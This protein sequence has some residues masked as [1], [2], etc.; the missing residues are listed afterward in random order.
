MQYINDIG[1]PFALETEL[2]RGRN[3]L[4]L[5]PT[6]LGGARVLTARR[7]AGASGQHQDALERPRLIGVGGSYT[8][9]AAP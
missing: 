1:G 2:A 8:S 3:W 7:G 6:V 9:I 4:D 5:L